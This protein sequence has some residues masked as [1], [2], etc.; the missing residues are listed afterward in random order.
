[1]AGTLLIP[2]GVASAASR[3]FKVTNASKRTLR[4]VNATHVPRV[5]CVDFRCVPTHYDIGFEGRPVDGTAVAPN[6]E[7]TWELKYWY[8]A[9]DI[10]GVAYNYA[11]KLT[12]SIEG[13]NGTFE[14]V[15]KTSNYSNDSTCQVIP[16]DLGTCTADSLKI[17]FR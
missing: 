11:A 5:L 9:G 17:T 15:I 10:F 3:G 14:A 16:K 7:Q 6:R 2:T 8:N 12:Y 4:L 13:T 1:V